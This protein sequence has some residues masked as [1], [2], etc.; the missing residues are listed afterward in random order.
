MIISTLYEFT[1]EGNDKVLKMNSVSNLKH[2][3]YTH[4]STYIC[5]YVWKSYFGV[6]I[7]IIQEQKVTFFNKVI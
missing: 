5:M 7:A 1:L 6:L 2:T 4:T 3:S